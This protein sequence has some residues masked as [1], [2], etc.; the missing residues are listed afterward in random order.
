MSLAIAIL[1]GIV[2]LMALKR[3][4][5][6]PVLHWSV[7]WLVMAL[8]VAVAAAPFG[9][10]TGIPRALAGLSVLATIVVITG[11]TH[12]RRQALQKQSNGRSSASRPKSSTPETAA[13]WICAGPLALLASLAGSALAAALL[14]IDRSDSVLYAVFAAIMAWAGL[15]VLAFY[16]DNPKK[17][18]VA[19]AL[20]ASSVIA[21]AIVAM[22]VF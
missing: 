3:T 1:L 16:T 19:L 11:Y 9:A 4:R 12:H 17:L 2:A 18:L 22:D 6:W 13:R 8:A 10:E 14:P 20:T 7:C 5:G 15:V 21:L